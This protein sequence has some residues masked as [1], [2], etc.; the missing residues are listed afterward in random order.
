MSYREQP[1]IPIYDIKGNYASSFGPGLGNAKNPL[2]IQNRTGDNRGYGNRL[3]GNVYADVDFLKNFT[4]HTSIGGESYSGFSR[5]F[6]Y[7]G[8]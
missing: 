5:A 6:A 2:A 7:P 1:I 4:F 3:F 8:V